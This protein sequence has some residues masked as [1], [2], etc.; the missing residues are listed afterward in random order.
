MHFEKL[1][2]RRK[3]MERN[4]EIVNLYS[5]GVPIWKIAEKFGISEAEVVKVLRLAGLIDR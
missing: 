3:T 4:R 2:E 1:E 5:E